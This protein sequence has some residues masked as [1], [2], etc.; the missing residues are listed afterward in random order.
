MSTRGGRRSGCG[1]KRIY[2]SDGT[3]HKKF[4]IKGMEGFAWI[5]ISFI[6]PR[7]TSILL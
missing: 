3:K 6:R 2:D 4:G 7:L 5:V 1:R